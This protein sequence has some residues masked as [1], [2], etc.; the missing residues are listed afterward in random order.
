MTKDKNA[1]QNHDKKPAKKHTSSSHRKVFDIMPPGRAPASAN[2]RSVPPS[3]KPPVADAQFVP[4]TTPSLASN[5]YDD[6]LLLSHH[7]SAELATPPSQAKSEA[8]ASLGGSG[9]NATAPGD[10]T[11][12]AAESSP[13]AAY[14]TP[15]AVADTATQTETPLPA[16]LELDELSPN[17]DAPAPPSLTQEVF[18]APADSAAPATLDQSDE[19]K[20]GQL[21]VEQVVKADNDIEIGAPSELPADSVDSANSAAPSEPSTPK[22]DKN[23]DELLAESGAPHLETHE[24]AAGTGVII[25]QHQPKR[26][27]WVGVILVIIASL[28]IAAVVLDILLDAEIIRTDLNVPHTNFF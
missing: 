5:P 27:S 4:P 3:S 17:P 16:D 19:A 7:G 22:S 10:N 26:H 21:A 1:A 6:K 18:S 25:S 2:S 13:S 8:P 14:N 12:P 24:P 15:S 9:Q 28:L 11:T 23:I 20:A